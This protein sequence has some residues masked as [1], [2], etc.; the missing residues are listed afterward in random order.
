M[1]VLWLSHL[2]PHPPQGGVLQRSY[3]LLRQASKKHEVHLVAISQ[4]A[5]HPTKERV[6]ESVAA[7]STMCSSVKVFPNQFD[8]SKMRWAMMAAATYFRTTPY[9]E[10]WL[11]QPDLRRYLAEL[12]RS[13]K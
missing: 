9:D 1:K 6:D 2:L 11:S 12:S 3:H 4:G 5:L 7:L 10:N 13:Q 8:A